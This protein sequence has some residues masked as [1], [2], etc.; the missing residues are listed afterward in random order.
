MDHTP[1]SLDGE[2]WVQRQEGVM[3]GQQGVKMPT[4]WE[5]QDPLEALKIIQARGTPPSPCQG[6]SGGQEDVQNL[7]DNAGS[8]PRKSPLLGRAAEAGGL[9]WMRAWSEVRNWVRLLVLFNL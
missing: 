2:A 7:E 5:A 6:H 1:H 8:F 3:Q 9:P 4:V